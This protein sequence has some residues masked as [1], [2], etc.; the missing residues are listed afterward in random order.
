MTT[1]GLK[2]LAVAG[3]VL[4]AGVFSWAVVS[5]PK[6]DNP[7]LRPRVVGATAPQVQPTTETAL[8]QTYV[9]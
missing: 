4:L 5:V 7:G 9:S 6:P 8:T 3:T 1:G 2:A